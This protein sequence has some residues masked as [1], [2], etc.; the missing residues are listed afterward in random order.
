[1]IFLQEAINFN[2]MLAGGAAGGVATGGI[3]ALLAAI[4]LFV[5]I[6][7]IALYIYTSFAF[8]AIARKTKYPYPGIAWIPAVGPALIASSAAK[9][10]WWPILL[11]IGFFIP[12]VNIIAAIVY[13]IF[14]IIWMWKTFEAVKRPG[15]WAI[16]YIIPILNIVWLVFVGIAAWGKSK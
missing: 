2:D 5:I 13:V 12:I 7:V 8:M 4:L 14:F 15:W 3:L 11:M 16:F 6:V 1:M 9:M 10:H